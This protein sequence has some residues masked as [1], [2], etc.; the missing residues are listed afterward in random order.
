MASSEQYLEYVLDLLRDVEGVAYRKMMGEYLL[1]ADGVMF[2]GVYDDR[3]LIKNTP[4]V[5]DAG[6]TEETPYEGAKKM[7]VVEADDPLTVR[8]L[9]S[10]VLTD[11]KR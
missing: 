3:F 2:G 5:S 4:S 7:L 9:V 1:Y 11:L 6:L 10:G 8:E